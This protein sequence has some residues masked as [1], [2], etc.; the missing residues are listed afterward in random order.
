MTSFWSIWVIVLTLACLFIIFGLLVWN[1]KNYT[2]VKE[3][4][5][6]G[7]EFDGIEE[8]NNPLP[9]WWT[10]MF[11]ATFIWSVYYLAAYPGLGN[12]EGLGK[13]TSSNQGIT[14]LAES[15]QAVADAK[16]D[17][18]F[19]KLDKEYEAAEERFGPIFN[20][21]AQVPVLDLVNS[22]F[23]GDAA[24]QVALENGSKHEQTDGQLAIEI[25]Q[26]LFSQ[27]CAQCHGSDARGGTGF[28]NLTDKDWLYGGTPDKIRETLLLGRIAAMPA[29]GPALGEQGIKEM[30]AH[31]LS[32]SGR[33]VNQKD[34]AA[35]EAKFA[36]C[37]ACHGADG[38]GS[39][40]HN[41]PFGAPNLT[42]NIW[43]Y[44][45]SQRAVEETLNHGRA[46][47][48]PA[49]KDILGEDKIHLLTAYVY[50]LSQDK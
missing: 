13:W 32:L 7:H 2:G 8:L 17:G 27:N 36:M 40:A 43:L 37:A 20:R 21:L 22:K 41:L 33:T 11:F 10:Y 45:G 48:M 25:G 38:K 39:V 18:R 15:K 5:S 9:K 28:P 24:Q 4:E 16:A 46:G 3:G 35:G 31:V 42:D 6:C 1:L 30:T 29:W 19:V 44:G 49:W 26:R 50:S 14:S 34:A 23:E 12:W 47:V